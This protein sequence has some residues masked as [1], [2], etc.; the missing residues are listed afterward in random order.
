MEWKWK[1]DFL[2]F[3]FHLICR[4]RM[5]D[6]DVLINCSAGEGC[7]I[8]C[9]SSTWSGC[10]TKQNPS[11]EIDG[12]G[13]AWRCFLDWKIDEKQPKF[14]VRE[15]LP[16]SD[17]WWQAAKENISRLVEAY[18]WLEGGWEGR[19]QEVFWRF[20]PFLSESR[21]P[22]ETDL[23]MTLALADE[24]T[25]YYNAKWPHDWYDNRAKNVIGMIT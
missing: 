13:G 20:P 22:S 8:Y 14:M 10:Q 23:L 16:K 2:Y 24:D 3:C 19:R 11:F 15:V 12:K 5:Q 17:N 25:N 9:G 7:R 18:L 21:C 4:R 1:W 6:I